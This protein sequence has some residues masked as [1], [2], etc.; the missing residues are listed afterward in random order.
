MA[1]LV[2]NSEDK[3]LLKSILNLVKHIK[4]SNAEIINN[5]SIFDKSP[6]LLSKEEAEFVTNTYLSERDNSNSFSVTEARVEY[7][8]QSKIW[9]ES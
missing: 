7:E 8:K 4:G 6:N 1:T 9:K 5:V 3:N 2:I